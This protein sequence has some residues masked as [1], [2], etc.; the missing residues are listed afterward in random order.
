MDFF[1]ANTKILRKHCLENNVEQVKFMLDV[2]P[3]FDNDNEILDIL[4]T[5]I[6]HNRMAIVKY[7]VEYFGSIEYLFK[8]SCEAA[9]I[10]IIK[11]MSNN[12]SI[13]DAV[14]EYEFNLCC[15][16]AII[17]TVKWMIDYLKIDGTKNDNIAFQR[18]CQHGHLEIAKLLVKSYNVDV[19]ARSDYAF[20]YACQNGHYDI[21]FWLLLVYPDIDVDSEGY[22]S[23]FISCQNGHLKILRLLLKHSRYDVTGG[24]D[25]LFRYCCQNNHLEMAKWLVKKYPGIDVHSEN[26][27]A[28]RFGN[29]EIKTWINGRK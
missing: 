15:Q 6:Q 13:T 27:Y 22:I 9:N 3:H 8:I 1:A 20:K 25:K 21:V 7:L 26:D 19:H 12:Y 24:N 17:E 14:I 23:I 5:V 4:S 29:Q 28:K 10:I 16:N 2:I 18:A 11:Y